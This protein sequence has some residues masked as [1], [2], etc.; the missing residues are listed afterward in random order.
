MN[1]SL[2]LASGTVTVVPYDSAWPSL[3]AAEVAR[4]ESVLRGRGVA[5]VFE[6][7]G[8]TAVPGLAAKPVLDILA[9]RASDGERGTAID[10]LRAAGYLH[11]GEQGIAGRDFFRRGDPR[12]YHLHLADTA[13]TFWRDHRRFRDYLRSHHDAMLAYAALKRTLAAQYPT[14][15]GAYINGKSAFVQEILDRTRMREE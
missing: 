3:Y 9:G 15:R 5:L 7:T 2:G 11:R 6:H 10:A 12:A 14:D 8:S 1:P 4:L 13:S